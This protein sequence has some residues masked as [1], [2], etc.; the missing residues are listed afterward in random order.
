M[1]RHALGVG[2]L[3]DFAERNH[4]DAEIVS[5][6]VE[7]DIHR[8]TWRQVA[9]RARR[10]ARWLDGRKIG[11]AERVATI[12]WNGYRHLELYYGVSASGRVLHTL[13]PRLSLAQLAWIINDADDRVVCF[14]LNFLPLVQAVRAQC[15]GVRHWVALSNADRLPDGDEQ[16]AIESYETLLDGES[17]APYTW[18]VSNADAASSLC[19]TSGT[20]GNPKGVLYSHLSTILHAYAVA[21]PDSLNLSSRNCVLAVVPMFHVNAWGLP[22]AA[23]LTGAKLVLP[24]PL[25]DGKS[26]YQL[27]EAEA[28]DVAAGVPTVWQMLLDHVA[29]HGLQFS[30]LQRTVVGGSACPAAMIDAFRDRYGIDT[31]HAWGMTELSPLG[32]VNTLKRKHLALPAEQQHALRLKQGRAVFGVEMRLLDAQGAELP[33]DGCSAGELAVRGPWVVERYFNQDADA[34]EDGWFRTGDIATIDEDGYLQITDR[35]KDVIKSGGEWISSIDVENIAMEHPQVA[36][37]ACIAIPHPKWDERPLLVV[38]AKP[39]TELTERAVLQF[40]GGRLPKWQVPDDVVFVESLSIG[41]TGKIVKHQLRERFADHAVQMK[42]VA[43]T[44]V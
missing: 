34:L 12:A 18:P 21:L 17:D 5:R 27:I 44:L 25:L 20:T 30:T 22:Y 16:P 8:T 3:I 23:A 31:V 11:A 2:T 24:G 15:P 42:E 28:V 36:M 9:A 7:E 33:F 4:G 10:I 43:E 39:G 29:T 37:A 19:Y 14:D 26:V 38:V 32:T 1:Q 6:R 41:A 13:N 40:I 35:A